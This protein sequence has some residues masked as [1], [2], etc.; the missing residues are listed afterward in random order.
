[1]KARYMS[2]CRKIQGRKVGVG[3]RVENTLIEAGGRRIGWGVSGRGTG[4]EG[5]I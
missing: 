1:M 3:R 4:K 2:Q 5:N